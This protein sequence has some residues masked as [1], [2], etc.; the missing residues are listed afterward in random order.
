MR[1][2]QY[3]TKLLRTLILNT[4]PP[5]PILN[6]SQPSVFWPSF[7]VYLHYW[8]FN[9]YYFSPNSC[10]HLHRLDLDPWIWTVYFVTRYFLG[11]LS[12]SSKFG[13]SSQICNLFSF[14]MLFGVTKRLWHFHLWDCLWKW[15]FPAVLYSI[16]ALRKGPFD[17]FFVASELFEYLSTLSDAQNSLYWTL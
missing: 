4:L 17:G 12:S 9:L 1:Q 15:T 10:A 3:L 16:F 14:I 7:S 5:S 11:F 13:R 2:N 8:A 6:W